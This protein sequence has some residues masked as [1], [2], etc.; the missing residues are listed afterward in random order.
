MKSFSFGGPFAQNSDIETEGG[1]YVVRIELPG[2]DQA[3]IDVNV[4][5]QSLKISG[6]IERKDETKK[7]QAFVQSYQSQHF[8]RYMTLP[9]PVK[10]ET[11]KTE[12]EGSVL[13]ITLEKS[14]S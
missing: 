10:P 11:L 4:E 6:N 1:K 13:I 7:D 9:G 8:E 12:Y 14:L 5:G 3:S 2:L